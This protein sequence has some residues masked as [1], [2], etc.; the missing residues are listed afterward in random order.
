FGEAGRG[1][2][3]GGVAYQLPIAGDF[4]PFHV[5]GKALITVGAG[6]KESLRARLAPGPHQLAL[7]QVA[8]KIVD[9][10]DTGEA[11]GPELSES[12]IRFI[13]C[14]L[15]LRHTGRQSTP[16]IVTCP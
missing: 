14:H 6:G 16:R 7:F 5:A 8:D 4:K 13:F 9:L 12:R 3:Q 2:L 1:I 11:D 10:S 15:E